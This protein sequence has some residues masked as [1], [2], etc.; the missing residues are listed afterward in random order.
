MTSAFFGVSDTPWCLCQ[1][2]I[3]FWHAPWCFKLMM[4]FVNRP[5]PKTI[6][7]RIRF[8]SIRFNRICVTYDMAMENSQ[9][10]APKGVQFSLVR[11]IQGPS[12]TISMVPG[13]CTTLNPN[14][15]VWFL[16]GC[17]TL[18]RTDARFANITA[19]S[20]GTSTRVN[21]MKRNFCE[22]QAKE[23]VK[24]R[25]GNVFEGH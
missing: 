8:I 1:P 5:E 20:S 24:G 21:T 10:L 13:P 7:F 14:N 12:P 6:I 16:L 25:Q 22:A 23:M 19:V 2:I 18:L 11:L 4:S 9:S 17:S 15:A 3:S